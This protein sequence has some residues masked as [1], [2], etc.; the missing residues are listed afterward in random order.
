MAQRHGNTRH[1]V[2][3][4][5]EAYRWLSQNTDHD[6][7]ILSW[8]DY[9]YQITG[10]ANRTVLVDNN[11]WNNTHIA[12]VGRTLASTEEEGYRLARHMGATHILVVFG[13]LANFSGDDISKFLWMIRIAAGV[14]PQVKEQNYYQNGRY[15]IDKD[16]SPGMKNC[17]MYR[18]VYYRFSEMANRRAQNQKEMMGWDSVRKAQVGDRDIKLKYF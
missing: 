17:L 5:R 6:A 10:M 3:D 4:Y 1:I 14:F 8:W 7:R 11:T 16:V 18:L 13:G 2:D 9:G 12:T 15:K